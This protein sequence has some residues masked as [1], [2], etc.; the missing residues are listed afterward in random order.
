MQTTKRQKHFRELMH[1]SRP[2]KPAFV[3]CTARHRLLLTKKGP[4]AAYKAGMKLVGPP[5]VRPV[6][7]ASAQHSAVRRALAHRN[8]VYLRIAMCG[9]YDD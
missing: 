5:L 4:I 7:G 6:H 9:H 1:F 8:N 3:I 2:R